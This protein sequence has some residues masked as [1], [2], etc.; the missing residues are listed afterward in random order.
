MMENEIYNVP[1]VMPETDEI[2]SIETA[3]RENIY[4]NARRIYAS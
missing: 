1:E 2:E 4:Y 3:K